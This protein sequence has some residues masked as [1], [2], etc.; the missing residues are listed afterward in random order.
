MQKFHSQGGQ[1]SFDLIITILIALIVLQ[2]TITVAKNMESAQNAIGIRDQAM[3][4]ALNVNQVIELSKTLRESGSQL[5]Y[6][7][8]F[9]TVFGSGGKMDLSATVSVSPGKIAVSATEPTSGKMVTKS[10]P[11]AS[12]ANTFTKYSG[13]IIA[14]T[15]ASPGVC[16]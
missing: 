15:S 2:S 10:I 4:I 5:S 1:I 9:I 3:Y 14:C 12:V 16:S 13:N 7:V 11:I 8:P 6:P